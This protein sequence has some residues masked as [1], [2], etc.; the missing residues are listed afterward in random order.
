MYL[1][2]SCEKWLCFTFAC[3]NEEE[4]VCMFWTLAGCDWGRWL[5]AGII[6]ALLSVHCEPL[7]MSARVKQLEREDG[8]AITAWERGET[9]SGR[10]EDGGVSRGGRSR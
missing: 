5:C 1:C 10:R 4:S 7:H 2:F 9:Q 3:V 6:A 8:V